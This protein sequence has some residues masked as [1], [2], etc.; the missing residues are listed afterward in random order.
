LKPVMIVPELVLIEG[1]AFLMGNN[2]GRADE[3]PAHPVLLAPFRAA[4]RPLTNAEYAAFVMATGHEPP[5]FLDDER[6]SD[7]AL[8]VVG[9]SWF[10]AVAYCEWLI[11]ESGRRYR[12]PTEAE[13]E[14][15]SLGGREQVDW[16]WG[17]KA[18]SERRELEAVAWLERPHVPSSVCANGY[19][20]LCMADNVHEWCSDWY[21]ADYYASSPEESPAGPAAGRR[22]VS[23][24]GSWRH[25]VK[26]NRLT[27]R[28]SLDPSFR[29]NDYGFRVY[30]DA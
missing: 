23:R 17:D 14:Y 12:L 2:R 4:V 24:G 18:P 13:R 10:D 30:T 8:P 16:P 25:Q 21:S 27:S 6:F 3:R 26:F 15:A 5:P 20:L 1:G 28:S 22:R 29:Y 11:A 9:V 7:P 19:G